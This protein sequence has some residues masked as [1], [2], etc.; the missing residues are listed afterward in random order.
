MTSTYYSRAYSAWLTAWNEAGHVNTYR[1]QLWTLRDDKV[2]YVYGDA[3]DRPSE[4]ASMGRTFP[5][6]LKIEDDVT[7]YGR[8]R[9]TP[10]GDVLTLAFVKALMQQEKL[11]QGEGS[12]RVPSGTA[13]PR[14]ASTTCSGWANASRSWWIMASRP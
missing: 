14:S 1:N 8:V 12:W 11:G 13:M 10:Y 7:F 3:D 9:V 6:S 5:H 4:R 2:S